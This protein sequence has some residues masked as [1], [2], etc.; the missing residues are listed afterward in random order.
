MLAPSLWTACPCNQLHVGN[1][2]KQ[3]PSPDLK[4]W[5]QFECTQMCGL[6]KKVTWVRILKPLHLMLCPLY[7]GLLDGPFIWSHGGVPH[8]CRPWQAIQ[9]LWPGQ[10]LQ[11]SIAGWR[12]S[13]GY[14]GVSSL[15]EAPCNSLSTS[16][17]IMPDRVWIYPDVLNPKQAYLQ[18][19]RSMQDW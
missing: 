5:K 3:I 19:V 8:E 17:S 1:L 11:A 14:S 18:I 10:N 15:Y 6:S 4:A 16:E 7:D 2:C 9:M 13:A 12:H